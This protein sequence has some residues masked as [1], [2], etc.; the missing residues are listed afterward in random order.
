MSLAGLS[1]RDLEY[2]LAVAQHRHCGRCAVACSVSQPALSGQVRKIEEL[3][4]VSLFERDR[5]HVIVTR[6]GE[7]MLGQARRVLHEAHRLV[8]LARGWDEPLAGPLALGAIAT[9]GQ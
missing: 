1:L 8:E 4:R 6:K 7:V 5:R 3:L 2:L 9:L